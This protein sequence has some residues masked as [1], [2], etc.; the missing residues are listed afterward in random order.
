MCLGICALIL[1]INEDERW[2]LVDSDGATFKVQ[3]DLLDEKVEKGDLVLVHAGFA[4]G[5]IRKEDAIERLR[6]MKEIMAYE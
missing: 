1:E 5:K 3:I 2:A 4:I 6:I